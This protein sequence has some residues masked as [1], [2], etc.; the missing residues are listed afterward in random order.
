M[1]EDGDLMDEKK[2][3]ADLKKLD[4]ERHDLRSMLDKIE[5]KKSVAIAKGYL[6]RCFKFRNS[7]ASDDKWWLYIKVI[8]VDEADI[9]CEE[10]QKTCRDEIDIRRYKRHV[11]CDDVLFSDSYVPI[12]EKEF[13]VAKENILSKMIILQEE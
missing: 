12:D 2:I 1:F 9:I 13:Q 10:I 4:E 6:G 11:Y 3:R 7:Y 5:D 8:E